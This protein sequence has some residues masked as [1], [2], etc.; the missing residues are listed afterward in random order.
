MAVIFVSH[1][2][3]DDAHATALE[4]W[5]STHGFTDF[6]IDHATIAG[7]EKWREALHASANSCRVAIC[8]VGKTGWLRPSAS[9]NSWMPGTW[10][11]ASYR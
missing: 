6:F 3:T 7:G 8:L 10:V 2:S 4:R 11:G 5:L 1:S 9:A